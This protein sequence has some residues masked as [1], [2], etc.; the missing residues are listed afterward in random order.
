[1]H[2]NQ[3]CRLELHFLELYAKVNDWLLV[4]IKVGSD[5]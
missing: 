3:L 5:Y 2:R 1:M 4:T